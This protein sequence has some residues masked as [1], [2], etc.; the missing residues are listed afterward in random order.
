MDWQRQ[1]F[2]Q[3]LLV[4]FLYG[5]LSG[6]CRLQK[7]MVT[8]SEMSLEVSPVAA[9]GAAD[10]AAFFGIMVALGMQKCLYLATK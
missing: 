2:L 1:F 9:Q 3:R 4:R 7:S 6:L 5:V 8:S 10:R